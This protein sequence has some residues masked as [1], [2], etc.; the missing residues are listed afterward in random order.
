MK[1]LFLHGLE[2]K[3]GGTK[4][5]VLEDAGHEVFNP[6]LP[7]DSLEESIEIAQDIVD[8]KNPDL[9]VGSSRGGAIGS[10]I[11]KRGA[12]LILIAPAWKLYGVTPIVSSNTTVLHCPTDDIVPIEH[13]LELAEKTGATVVECGACHRMSDDE[14]LGELLKA[15]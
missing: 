5:K 12:K 14:A 2:S 11:D 15:V 13:S 9:V 7:K 10:A 3:P 1:I 6:A 4:A 8:T